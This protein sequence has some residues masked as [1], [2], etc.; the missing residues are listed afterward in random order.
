MVL[1][2]HTI[3]PYLKNI[4]NSRRKCKTYLFLTN[5]RRHEDQKNTL[6]NVFNRVQENILQGKAYAYDENGHF[7]KLKK[8]KSIDQQVKINT[9]LWNITDKFYKNIKQ[10]SL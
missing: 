9:T 4:W 2:P 8:V 10:Y 1:M 5:I 3:N 6:W 7:R